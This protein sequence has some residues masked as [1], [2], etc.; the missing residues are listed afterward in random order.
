MSGFAAAHFAQR[1][2]AAKRF[3]AEFFKD[4][5]H[6]VYRRLTGEIKSYQL[7]MRYK[8]WR[9]YDWGLNVIAGSPIMQRR[10]ETLHRGWLNTAYHKPIE[11]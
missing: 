6:A 11:E 9:M 3:D 8:P 1:A 10:F 2:L 7:L 4:Y 5:D